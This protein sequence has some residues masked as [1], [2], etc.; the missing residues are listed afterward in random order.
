EYGA[1]YCE[2]CQ[3]YREGESPERGAQQGAAAQYQREESH[4]EGARTC[5]DCGGQLRWIEEYEMWY[6][7]RC[8]DYK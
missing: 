6:C 7:E 5:P 2:R 3:E 8:G 4:T 1:W